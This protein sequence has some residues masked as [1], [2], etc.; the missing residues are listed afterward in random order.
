MSAKVFIALGCLAAAA[1]VALGA[2]GAH[3]LRARLPADSIAV[4]QTAV[5]Y[6]FYHA[7]GLIALGVVAYHLPA[8][9][10]L[11]AA[12]WLM[13]AGMVLFCGSLYALAFGAARGLG[14]LTPVGG[15]A[16]IAAWI[17]AAV[18]VARG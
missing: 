8:S 3:A 4:Y 6:H 16:F 18:A 1:A 13:L 11:R 17:V 5:Q 9:G 10:T 12:G 14:M 7:L 2:F 15:A